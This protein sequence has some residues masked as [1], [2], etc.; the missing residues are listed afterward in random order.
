VAAPS[1]RPSRYCPAGSGLIDS[2]KRRL[3]LG[4]KRLAAR[5]PKRYACLYSLSFE[6]YPSRRC[7]VVH[8]HAC[9]PTGVP[10]GSSTH[11]TAH[12]GVG[13]DPIARGDGNVG[14]HKTA[15]VRYQGPDLS[16]REVPMSR[17]GFTPLAKQTSDLKT[18]PSP[19]IA[20]GSTIRL[21]CCLWRRIY[22]CVWPTG[23]FTGRPANL[24]DE[25]LGE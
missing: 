3:Q 22:T 20:V 13:D 25:E 21:S 6:G 14:D 15:R 11:C 7:G 17:N 4:L 1:W 23:G 24:G 10:Q 16:L 18:L 12:T 8:P 5:A 2:T 9:R 19:A